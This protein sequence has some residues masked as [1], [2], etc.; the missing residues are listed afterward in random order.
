MLEYGAFVAD[1]LR[2]AENAMKGIGARSEYRRTQLPNYYTTQTYAA[3]VGVTRWGVGGVYAW[4]TQ[5]DLAARGQAEAQV[6]TQERIRGNMSASM[7]VQGVEAATA[8]IR[9]KM[10]QKYQMEF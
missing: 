9:R 6:R 8:D 3:P 2:Q 7:I 5:E 4:N 1:S 10:T